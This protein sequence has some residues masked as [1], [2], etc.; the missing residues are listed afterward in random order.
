VFPG[1]RPSNEVD[2]ARRSI[3][4]YADVEW[5]LAAWFRLGV[6]GRAERYSDFGSTANGKLTVRVAQDPRVV[7]RGTVSTGFRAP[8]LGRNATVNSF[9]GIRT[10]PSHSPF[11]FNGRALVVRVGRTF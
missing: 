7:V 11:G 2:A 10:F 5:D 8:S 1:F 3:A 6:A 4:G 9:N